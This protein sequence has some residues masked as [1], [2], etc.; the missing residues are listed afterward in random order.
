MPVGIKTPNIER[1]PKDTTP[2]VTDIKLSPLQKHPP[3]ADIATV[4]SIRNAAVD[5]VMDLAGKL[6]SLI[7]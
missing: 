4:V 1:N 5:L 7:E 3:F 2:T 6:N